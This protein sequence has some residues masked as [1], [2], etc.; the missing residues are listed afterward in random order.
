M[1]RRR[2][3]AYECPRFYWVSFF[4]T[5]TTPAVSKS[6]SAGFYV[7]YL[8]GPLGRR[9]SILSTQPIRDK[10]KANPKFVCVCLFLVS[11]NVALRLPERSF[12]VLAQGRRRC[13]PCRKARRI[14]LQRSSASPSKPLL[15][16]FTD[17]SDSINNFTLFE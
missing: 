17:A 13:L 3:G 5:S 9:L 8:I 15:P 6:C 2:I 7:F 11:A 10:R 16:L 1:I 14:T 12:G 4:S